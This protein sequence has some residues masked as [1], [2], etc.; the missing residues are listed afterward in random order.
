[1]REISAVV[2]SEVKA[3]R[4]LFQPVWI[5]SRGAIKAAP[6]R[7]PSFGSS[8]CQ[9]SGGGGRTGRDTS[10]LLLL[11]TTTKSMRLSGLCTGA[12]E[13]KR[14]GTEHPRLLRLMKKSSLFTVKNV[15]TGL[16]AATASGSS[17]GYKWFRAY[18]RTLRSVFTGSA[19]QSHPNEN[20]GGFVRRNAIPRPKL[21]P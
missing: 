21:C 2:R 15:D 19:T 20:F 18:L 11:G 3:E 13:P 6:P 14:S 8:S 5:C 1:M 9:E 17:E 16:W 12:W 7:R 10:A 4:F